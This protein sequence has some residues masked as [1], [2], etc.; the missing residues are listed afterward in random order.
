MAVGAGA[1]RLSQLCKRQKNLVLRQFLQISL[2]PSWALEFAAKVWPADA[3]EQ[4]ARYCL[5]ASTALLTYQGD[6]GVCLPGPQLPRRP[7][8][9]VLTEYV[10][11]LDG[12]DQLCS[13][14]KDFGKAVAEHLRAQSWACCMELCLR[15]F[16]DERVLR[17]HAHVFLRQESEKMRCEDQRLLRF[18]GGDPHVVETIWGKRV[19]RG[20]WAGAYYCLAPKHGSLFRYAPLVPFRDFPVDPGWVFNMIEGGKWVT[21]RRASS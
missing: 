4:R 8:P 5:Q 15:T 9:E 2:A 13:A 20:N 1:R 11:G 12:V 21:R 16:E 7:T 3:S 14:L 10:Q 17:L 6:W 18:L 19:R